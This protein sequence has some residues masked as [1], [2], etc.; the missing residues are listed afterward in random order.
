MSNPPNKRKIKLALPKDPSAAYANMVMVTHNANEVIF[1]FIQVLPNDSHARVQKRIAMTP[2][3]A[4]MFLK[5][6]DSNIQRYEDKHGDIDVPA[7][8]DSLADQLFK[9]IADQNKGDD[10]DE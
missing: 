7:Q 6:L 10:D 9:G 1:D 4:K 5:A 8:P 2:T 3:H